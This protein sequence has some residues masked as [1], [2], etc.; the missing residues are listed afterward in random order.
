MQNFYANFKDLKKMNEKNPQIFYDIISKCCYRSLNL[1]E[2]VELC[3][4]PPVTA[5]GTVRR[6]AVMLAMATSSGLYLVGQ[7]CPPVTMLGLRS[8]PS[9]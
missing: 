7:L 6:K 2:T 3:M 8:V 5:G 1:E 4:P 9:R